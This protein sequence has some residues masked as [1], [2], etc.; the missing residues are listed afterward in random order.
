MATD[1]QIAANRRNAKKST[2]PRT[3]QG[4]LQSRRNAFRHGLTAETAPLENEND[5]VLFEKKIV[6]DFEPVTATDHELT[7]R[8]A[9]LLWRLRRST[10][11][12]SGLLS[13]QQ[14]TLKKNTTLKYDPGKDP[15]RDLR[16]LLLP[17]KSPH[18]DQQ[19]QKATGTRCNDYALDLAQCFLPVAS[20]GMLDRFERYEKSLRRQAAQIL[21]IL[22]LQQKFLF[23]RWKAKS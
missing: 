15:L 10:A 21:I 16:N 5:Y 17:A 18:P 6:A 2:G 23:K 7:V 3:L 19:L 14:Q 22:N 13:L 9:S 4:K 20:T 1:R 12:E 8:L 11:I